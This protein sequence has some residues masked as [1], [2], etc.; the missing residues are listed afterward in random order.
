MRKNRQKRQVVITERQEESP[1]SKKQANEGTESVDI[2]SSQSKDTQISAFDFFKASGL[3][4]EKRPTYFRGLVIGPK[5]K[6]TMLSGNV[7][8]FF[9]SAEEY[10]RNP[11]W[12]LEELLRKVLGHSDE[13]E[14]H[15]AGFVF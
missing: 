3:Y 2:L 12:D 4:K 9:K 8:E 1:S 13:E 7:D 14:D 6:A 11:G 15:R 5:D 10:V